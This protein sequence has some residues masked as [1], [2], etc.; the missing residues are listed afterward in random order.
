MQP[1]HYGH[2]MTSIPERR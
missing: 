1:R 2:Q